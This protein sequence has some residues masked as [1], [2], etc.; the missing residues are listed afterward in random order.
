MTAEE[1]ARVCHEANRALTFLIADV[2]VQPPWDE[3]DADMKLSCMKGVSVAILMLDSGV[4][5]ELRAKR[6]HELWCEERWAA[7]W[8]WGAT[9]SVEAKLHPALRAFSELPEAV[10]RKDAVFGAIVQALR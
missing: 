10:R 4:A 8:Q 9:K 2:P 1:I 7:G 6:Q 3:V 5:P